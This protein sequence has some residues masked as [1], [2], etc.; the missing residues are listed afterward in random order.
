LI[1]INPP[2]HCYVTALVSAFCGSAA[3]LLCGFD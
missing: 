2:R 3:I 1:L